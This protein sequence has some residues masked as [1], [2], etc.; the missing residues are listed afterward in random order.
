MPNM[1]SVIQNYNP[2]LLTEHTTTATLCLGVTVKN[3]NA[4]RLS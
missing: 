1:K 3:Q 2:N 4:C